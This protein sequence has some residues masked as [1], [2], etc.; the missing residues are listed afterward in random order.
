MNT[1]FFI[2]FALVL[3]TIGTYFIVPPILWAIWYARRTYWRQRQFSL[4]AFFFVFT[5]ATLLIGA[6]V[7]LMRS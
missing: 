3:S 7:T 4:K 2:V 6:F 1:V 5:A